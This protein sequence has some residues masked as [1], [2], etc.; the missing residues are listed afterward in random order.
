MENNKKN[1]NNLS[2]PKVLLLMIIVFFLGYFLANKKTE[3]Y[4]INTQNKNNAQEIEVNSNPRSNMSQFWKVW[5]ILESK[6]IYFNKNKDE[7][8]IQGAIAGMVSSLGDPYTVFF[9][10]TESKAF[11][12]SIKGEFGGIGIE[13]GVKDKILTVISPLKD[14]PAYKA[15]IKSGDKILKIGEKLTSDLSIDEAVGLIRGD[16]GTK[17]ILTTYHDGDD[18]AKTV[19]LIRAII[20]IPTIDTKDIKDKKIFI[21]SL[22]N[23]NEKSALLFDEAMNTFIKTNYNKLVI[24]LRGNPGGYI[25]NAVDIAGWFIEDGKVAV[26]EDFVGKDKNIEHRIKSKINKVKNKQI[27]TIINN[28]SASA[29]EILAGA[30][31]DYNISKIVGEQS[32]GKGSVQQLFN[33]GEGSTLKVTVAKWLTPNG[34]SISEKGITPDIKIKLTEEELKNQ[35][36]D[37]EKDYL[38]EKVLNLFK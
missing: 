9:E 21:I 31:Q 29:S 15:G 7:Q 33:V 16:V 19:E 32:F 14:S 30:L 22:Y 36:D 35:L 6:S 23:F 10:P 3:S 20:K 2:Y 11:N 4:S 12:D 37:L 24:D 27:L 8:K 1:K 17:V 38:L 25:E 5:G 13:F 34:N 18:Q 26:S 28:G